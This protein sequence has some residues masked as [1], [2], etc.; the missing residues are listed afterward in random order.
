MTIEKRGN[1]Y[2]I[3][4]YHNGKLYLV[5]V[6]HEP[7]KTEA[8][9]LIAKEWEKNPTYKGD[10]TLYQACDEYIDNR[11][12]IISPATV[13]GYRSMK[14]RIPEKYGKMRISTMDSR[15]LQSLINEYAVGRSAKTTGNLSSFIISVLSTYDV[16][17]KAPTLP[18][19]EKKSPYIPTKED[20]TKV[21]DAIKGTKYEVPITLAA[22]G[23]RRSEICALTLDDLNGNTF[24]INK[25]MVQNEKKE[26]IIKSTKTSASTRTV[27]IPDYL[28]EII[29]EQGY[30]F[31]GE[32][33]TIYKNLQRAQDKAGVP[34]FQ[35]HKLRHF[36]ASYMHDL[37]FSDKQIQEAGGW[38][39]GSRIMKMVY[40]HAMELDAAKREMSESISNLRS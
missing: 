5:T 20:V 14:R 30:V 8:M 34:R 1:S 40:Q 17:I 9:L 31:N 19:T 16:N 3:R 28:A 27:V 22:L 6:D 33:G 18:Q 37:G 13:V 12:N 38:R 35:L 23:L 7:S 24:T 25:A 2:R 26:W 10:K 4:Q 39:D 36:F 29:R 15:T 21:F 11:S 32:P